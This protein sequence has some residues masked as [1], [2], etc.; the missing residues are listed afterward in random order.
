ME[1]YGV[2]AQ[3]KSSVLL[4]VGVHV[5]VH[6]ISLLLKRD[7][8]GAIGSGLEAE[9]ARQD[10]AATEVASNVLDLG[11]RRAVLARSMVAEDTNSAAT[12]ALEIPG[13]I[14][15]LPRRAGPGGLDTAESEALGALRIDK[16]DVTLDP[17]RGTWKANRIPAG[18]DQGGQVGQDVNDTSN[19]RG[20]NSNRVRLDEK[21]QSTQAQA[22]TNEVEV[23]DNTSDG[24][25]DRGVEEDADIEELFLLKS[26]LP[27]GQSS[28]T[29]AGDGGHSS[30]EDGEE[31]HDDMEEGVVGERS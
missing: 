17:S 13:S 26:I 2:L 8:H 23:I 22:N 29:H 20:D 30:G 9:A 31:L 25:I 19:T 14:N 1:W 28:G 11:D 4:H 24:E 12:A 16:G 5:V 21:R 7:T 18:S 27:A 15:T 10:L 3:P 6:S